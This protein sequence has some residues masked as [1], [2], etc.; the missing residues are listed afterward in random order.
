M[1]H[2]FKDLL[3]YTFVFND[4]VIDALI[5]LE[6][7]P[8]KSIKLINHTINAQQIW[9]ARIKNNKVSRGVWDISPLKEL[10]VINIE[11]YENS[12]AIVNDCDFDE[13]IIYS[14]TK[15]Q[16][17]E[18]TIREMLFHAVNHSTYHR[19]QIA[20]DFKQNGIEPLITD[21]IFY[22]RAQI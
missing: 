20:S 12:L 7:K 3:E 11:N 19:G 13:K 9:N 22:K 6:D 2:F 1:N 17:F 15:G 8:D 10:R 16:T 4:K 18:N 5:Q 21:Y 14:N